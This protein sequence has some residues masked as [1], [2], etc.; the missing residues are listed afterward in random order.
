MIDTFYL[1]I[2]SL[3]DNREKVVNLQFID[4]VQLKIVVQISPVN[5]IFANHLYTTN[6]VS[7]CSKSVS[8]SVHN[9]RGSVASENFGT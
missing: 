8:N 5:Q 1:D 3:I 7:H 2:A 6:S 4:E 9:T